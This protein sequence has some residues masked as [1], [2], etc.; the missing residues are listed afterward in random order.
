LNSLKIAVI[1]SGISGLSAAWLLSQRH[2]V[3]LIEGDSRIGG[4]SN[5][6]ECS[7]DQGSV[8]VDTGF[9]VYNTATYPNLTALFDYLNVSTSPSDMGFAVSLKGGSYEYSGKGIS[10]LL[11]GIGNLANPSHWRMMAD[12]VR[13]FRN[14]GS[15]G[16]EIGEN[17]SLGQFL[18]NHG[19]SRAFIDLHLLPVAGAI[20]SSSPQHMLDYPA[21]CFLR[22]FENHGL[23]NFY[24]RPQ[25]RTV[26]GGSR[27]YVQ[28]LMSDSR[29]RIITNCPVH[30]IARSANGVT[31][32]STNAYRESFDHVV[33][34]THADQALTM[35][36]NP[37]EMEAHCLSAFRYA[38]NRAIL[39]SDETLM[40]RRKRLWSSWNYVSDGATEPDSNTVTYWMNA[41]QPLATKT[42]LFVTLN[43]Q[44]LPRKETIAQEFS[45]GHPIFNSA[46]EKMQK[47]LWS[48]QGQNRTWFC[49]AHFGAGFHEDGLQSG[50]AVAEQLGGS[51]RP[52]NVANQNSRIHVTPLAA[53]PKPYHLAAAE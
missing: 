42:N 26:T 18:S 29:M 31:I 14:A 19:Y 37:T 9:I 39:H 4:H 27:E 45:Y 43:P 35:L 12:L 24:D 13:F 20:W 40:P 16:R 21:K 17:V 53:L 28:R 6:V 23:L 2:D 8:P 48:L 33:V 50:L 52:W 1:G 41:L 51:L 11:G 10:Q 47:Q 22:F 3:T 32:Q 36:A 44:R 5:T 38:A 46:T 25:W 15:E 30:N 49:G 7:T 34:A